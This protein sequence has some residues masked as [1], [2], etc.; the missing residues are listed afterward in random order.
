MGEADAVQFF[1][2]DN[3]TNLPLKS[4][5]ICKLNKNKINL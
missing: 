3:C 5:D 1:S 4:I 2:L